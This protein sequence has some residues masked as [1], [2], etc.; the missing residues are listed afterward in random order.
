[1]GYLGSAAEMGMVILCSKL[2]EKEQWI[3]WAN[4]AGR[5][6]D[7]RVIDA[8]G[9]RYRFNFLDWIGSYA[10]DGAGLT[11]NV[12]AFLEEIIN[13]LEPDKSGGGDNVF[14][15]DALHQMLVE[16]V[17]LN[18]LSGYE[19]S[20]PTLRDIVR[21]A[22]LSPEQANDPAWREKNACWFFLEEARKRCVS[23]DPEVQADY[24][25]CRAYWLED[26]ARLSEKTRSIITLMFTKL[27]QPFS[28]RPLRKLLC[29][30]TTITPEAT[31]NGA[32][33]VIDIATQEYRLVG[34]IAALV[35]KYAWQV[36]V[37]RRRPAPA[38]EY[39]RPVCCWA[40][41]AASNF[42]SRSDETFAA[43]ARQSAGCLVYLAQNVSQYRKRLGGNDGFE[44]T[45]GAG[46][47]LM[48]EGEGAT[49]LTSSV[50][51]SEQH[52]FFLEPSAFTTLK[53]GGH[54]YGFEVE[55]ILYRGGHLFSDGKPYK[56]LVF[57]Q[58]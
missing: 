43:A 8:S 3:K 55:G 22:P 2:T 16:D 14:W 27:A 42:L 15:E 37:L 54:G 41:E 10:A 31:F 30:D 57:R 36:A 58:R 11:I 47:T 18:Q 6:K 17:Q 46:N 4:E 7:V 50:S 9:E 21:S 1:M 20:L 53:R 13:S 5:G 34:R 51:L 12:V 19:L 49:S 25:E 32:I 40:D 38:G 23:A 48:P 33:L 39:L 35:F 52:R 28:S 56:R 29:T 24:A 26:F 44:V 45:T